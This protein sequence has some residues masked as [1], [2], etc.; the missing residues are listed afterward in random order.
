MRKQHTRHVISAGHSREPRPLPETLPHWLVF[1]AYL[2]YLRAMRPQEPPETKTLCL[3]I[4]VVGLVLVVI[5][6]V[7]G[8]APEQ[9]SAVLH[10]WPI[11]P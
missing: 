3:L 4:T 2:T 6:L 8:G 7:A 1:L 9:V 11:I 10:N 5:A